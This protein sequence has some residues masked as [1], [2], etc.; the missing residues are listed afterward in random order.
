MSAKQLFNS[1]PKAVQAQCASVR[2]CVQWVCGSVRLRDIHSQAVGFCRLLFGHFLVVVMHLRLSVL[3]LYSCLRVC[4]HSESLFFCF[5][6]MC[7]RDCVSAGTVCV[8]ALGWGGVGVH[9]YITLCL[10]TSH[11]DFLTLLVHQRRNASPPSTFVFLPSLLSSDIS[12]QN[13]FQ[14]KKTTWEIT[15]YRC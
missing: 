8:R 7:M 13:H 12:H 15:L 2:V 10:E 4:L 6:R 14:L 11:G 9:T 1:A 3:H 5:P